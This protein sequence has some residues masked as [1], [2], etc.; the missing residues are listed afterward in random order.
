MT[1]PTDL[2]LMMYFDGELPEPRRSEV[3]AFVESGA[4]REKAQNKL[5]GL[6]LVSDIVRSE[7]KAR[8]P[9]DDRASRAIA[10]GVMAVIARER[11]AEKRVEKQPEEKKP[12]VAAPKLRGIDP[13]GK[14]TAAAAANDN[15]KVIFALAA[16]AAA[17]AA[18]L[19]IWGRTP[20][21]EAPPSAT[22]TQAEVQPGGDPD[23]R[24]PDGDLQRDASSTARA[25]ATTAPTNEPS[26]DAQQA[27]NDEDAPRS[28]EVAAVNFGSRSGAIY[29]V[30]GDD[31][32][33]STTVV[34]VRDE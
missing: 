17:A 28:V 21:A 18:A 10:D 4:G 15:G 11:A 1:A 22:A 20:V 9:A 23:P 25:E 29:Y 32:P 3:R 33:T 8:E 26:K 34:W 13:P 7:A 6:G 2:E 19:F 31:K 12:P 16:A 14:S 5:A 24:G 27:S 30:S